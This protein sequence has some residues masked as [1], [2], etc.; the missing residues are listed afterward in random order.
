MQSYAKIWTLQ[1][2]LQNL[3]EIKQNADDDIQI[4]LL[5]I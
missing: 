2:T 3:L 5:F 1:N 4:N